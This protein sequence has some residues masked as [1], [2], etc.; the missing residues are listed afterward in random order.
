M[1]CLSVV[2]V[3]IFFFVDSSMFICAKVLFGPPH[4][5]TISV[6]LPFV[7]VLYQDSDSDSIYGL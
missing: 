6:I 3:D 5:F 2:Y 1:T 4:L 7:D